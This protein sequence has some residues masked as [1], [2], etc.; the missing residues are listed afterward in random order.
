MLLL[1]T[2]Q[3][4]S[5]AHP[6]PKAASTAPATPRGKCFTKIP[7]NTLLLH[8]DPAHNRLTFS[9]RSS[10]GGYTP[11]SVLDANDTRWNSSFGAG[12]ETP[13]SVMTG[14]V[15]GASGGAAGSSTHHHGATAAALGGAGLLGGGIAGG[16]LGGPVD[17][18]AGGF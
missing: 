4:A 12:R 10:V 13:G 15:L 2:T 1:S 17:L 16:L 11:P 6:I 14:G 18:V 5:N 3:L 9:D 7:C 8:G